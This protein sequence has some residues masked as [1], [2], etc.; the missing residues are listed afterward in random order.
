MSC[1][2]IYKFNRQGDAHLYGEVQNAWRGAMAI[3]LALEEKYLPPYESEWMG[4]G[5]PSRVFTM[6]PE[7]MKEIWNLCESDKVTRS[8]K[9]CLHTT[10]DKCLIHKEDIPEV[11]KAFREFKGET[12]L[13]EQA[14]ILEKLANDDDCIAVGWNQTSCTTP[15]WEDYNGYD[16]ENDIPIPYNCITGEEHYWLFDDLDKKDGG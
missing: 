16:D 3:W 15:S 5:S 6:M 9:I 7:T 4:S 2:E 14:D 12:S 11:V 8:E 10:F 1:T 13:N